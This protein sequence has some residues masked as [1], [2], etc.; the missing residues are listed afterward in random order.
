MCLNN[1]WCHQ[2]KKLTADSYTADAERGFS[3]QNLICSCQRDNFLRLECPKLLLLFYLYFSTIFESN[4]LFE[5]P[6]SPREHFF[7]RNSIVILQNLQVYFFH[8]AW[9]TL[10]NA[11]ELLPWNWYRHNM[12]VSTTLKWEK[13]VYCFMRLNG[14]PNS[15][16]CPNE[17]IILDAKIRHYCQRS[18][19]TK[20]C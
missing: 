1:S 8:F 20:V 10:Q 7:S 13:H 9:C 18:R 14:F 2:R 15:K 19:L 12:R 6:Y 4:L 3:A 17:T 11:G 5:V 16:W